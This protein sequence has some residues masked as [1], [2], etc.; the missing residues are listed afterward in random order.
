MS[1]LVVATVCG[2]FWERLTKE[3][4]VWSLQWF[5]GPCL[6]FVVVRKKTT[7]TAPEVQLGPHVLP[8][9]EQARVLC[10]L[11][12]HVV[13]GWSNETLIF[14][15]F[16]LF[17]CCFRLEKVPNFF[18]VKGIKYFSCTKFKNSVNLDIYDIYV[19][20]WDLSMTGAL[21][22]T[23]NNMSP[24]RVLHFSCPSTHHSPGPE[25]TTSL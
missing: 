3:H 23:I 12:Y 14:R 21:V 18:P 16:F 17:V 11:D 8:L 15:C 7:V 22:A 9:R 1:S 2:L 19:A 6:W 13:L 10:F 24:T 25:A 20:F 4:C 5:L